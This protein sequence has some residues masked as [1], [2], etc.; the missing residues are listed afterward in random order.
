MAPERNETVRCWLR[1]L[2][3]WQMRG[4]FIWAR[5][6]NSGPN[7]LWIRLWCVRLHK[8][9]RTIQLKNPSQNT[10]VSITFL[11]QRPRKIGDGPA[12]FCFLRRS[13]EM[14]G[15]QLPA[16][17]VH[18]PAIHQFLSDTHSSLTNKEQVQ[19]LSPASGRK[20][21][22]MS[23][24]RG[25]KFDPDYC[26]FPKTCKSLGASWLWML[27]KA[28]TWSAY[29]GKQSCPAEHI[30]L[31]IHHH[32]FHGSEDK[33]SLLK[34]RFLKVEGLCRKRVIFQWK[35][36]QL[37]TMGV[38]FLLR[39]GPICSPPLLFSRRFLRLPV[40]QATEKLEDAPS[41]TWL[42]GPPQI[43]ARQ[44]VG[45][46]YSGAQRQKVCSAALRASC[47]SAA[48]PLRALPIMTPK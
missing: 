48:S 46:R 18:L 11:C 8:N 19:A 31:V 13:P 4:N 41:A 47:L 14:L 26:L 7:E 24:P 2:C 34:W 28:S 22:W 42:P 12:H 33:V 36:M 38:L 1:S 10:Q 43:S 25:I 20:V 23:T 15:T 39:F 35:Q 45:A 17:S 3:G 27:D 6:A 30:F 29:S 44:C 37:K 21:K 9:C 32:V 5:T 16:G 40:F